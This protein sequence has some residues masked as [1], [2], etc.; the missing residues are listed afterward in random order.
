[1]GP[2]D[3]ESLWKNKMKS[4]KIKRIYF[5]ILNVKIVHKILGK[6]PEFNHVSYDESIDVKDVLNQG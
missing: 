2:P 5:P 1:M 4:M 3:E 6:I